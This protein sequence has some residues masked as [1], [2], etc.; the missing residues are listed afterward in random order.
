MSQRP[1]ST[2]QIT[3]SGQGAGNSSDA[4]NFTLG[5]GETAVPGAIGQLHLQ[6]ILFLAG[7]SFVYR[8]S[9][10]PA[11]WTPADLTV[12]LPAAMFWDVIPGQIS[13]TTT[14]LPF[15]LCYGPL[16]PGGR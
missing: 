11:G 15:V 3:V 14:A 6:G 16:G 2:Y 4:T 5:A 13:G 7:G 10:P 9:A 1:P 8:P 12:V